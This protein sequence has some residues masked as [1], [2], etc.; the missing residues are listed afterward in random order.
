[1]KLKG[2]TQAEIA[3]HLD[4]SQGM[5]SKFLR[6]PK[7]LTQNYLFGIADRLG[8]QVEDLF[9]DPARPSR[10]E[11]LLGLD[12]DQIEKVIQIIDVFRRDGTTG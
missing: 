7:A 5:V 9:R 8:C 2:V 1:M 6:N 11:L 4:V 12:E 10:E 3:E